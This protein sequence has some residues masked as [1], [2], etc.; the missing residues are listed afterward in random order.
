M[1]SDELLFVHIPRT[2]GASFRQICYKNNI[3]IQHHNLRLEED[4]I[5][6]SEVSS[7]Y[8]CIFT[9]FR[10]PYSRLVSSYFYLKQ[11]GQ[12][13]PDE[14]DADKFVR[15]FDSFSDFVLNGLEQAIRREQIHFLPQS[16]WITD[17]NGDCFIDKVEKTCN[18]NNLSN[19]ISQYIDQGTEYYVLNTSSHKKWNHYYDSFQ[20]IEKVR[21]LYL[22]DITFYKNI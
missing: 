4:F 22:K 19:W 16:Y 18:F 13:P 5:H 9:L 17:S 8:E 2:G 6:G 12:C 10:N 21:D 11:G 3:D 14:N 15:P 7:E 1:R 20:I